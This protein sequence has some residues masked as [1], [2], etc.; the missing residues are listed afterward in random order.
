MKRF[1]TSFLTFLNGIQDLNI[2]AHR[3]F[4]WEKTR[5]AVSAEKIVRHGLAET[6]SNPQE[7]E[8][9]PNYFL[10]CPPY[11]AWTAETSV[12]VSVKFSWSAEN[13]RSVLF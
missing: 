3:S 13:I 10:S 1:R 2:P 11:A 4:G 9:I 8:R 6:E 12:S 5:H 7:T